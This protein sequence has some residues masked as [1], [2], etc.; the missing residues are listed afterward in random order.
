MSLK[1]LC[2]L[3]CLSA[4]GKDLS[5]SFPKNIPFIPFP[6]PHP[7]YTSL[8]WPPA[9]L[10]LLCF[11]CLYSEIHPYE[12]VVTGFLG[13]VQGE[14][15]FSVVSYLFVT[16]WIVARQAP[17]SMGFSK[18]EHWSGLPFPSPGDLPDPGI[19]PPYHG[20]QVL[21]HW[22]TW[23]T[24]GWITSRKVHIFQL[25]WWSD[26]KSWRSRLHGKAHPSLSTQSWKK[27][28][29]SKLHYIFHSNL[30]F[31]SWHIFSVSRAWKGK[32]SEFVSVRET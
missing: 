1:R 23:E 11:C 7:S 27:T 4:S 9:F 21:Y 6:P 24:Q 22:V 30:S 19:K 18:Q 28:A 15:A 25:M 5:L 31:P 26:L 32:W 12:S 13:S 17:L 16:P 14:C 3:L 2:V 20:R 8:P 29:P 10:L